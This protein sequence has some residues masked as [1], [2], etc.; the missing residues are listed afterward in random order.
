MK[1]LLDAYYDNNFG[2]DLFI[3][4]V[5]KRYPHHMFYATTGSLR[6]MFAANPPKYPQKAYE[7]INSIPNVSILPDCQAFVDSGFFDGYIMIGGDVFPDQCNYDLRMRF[8]ESIKKT[9]GFAAMIGFSLYDSYSEKTKNDMA[10]VFRQVDFIAARDATSTA[11][12]R[13][14]L[15]DKEI[16]AG[17]DLAFTQSYAFDGER[18][19]QTLGFSV[20]KSLGA[21]E[22]EYQ[23]YCQAMASIADAYL[24]RDPENKV[25]FIGLSNGSSDD[26]ETIMDIVGLMHQ[27]ENVHISRYEGCVEDAAGEIAA[28]GAMV[29]TRFHSLVFALINHIPFIPVAYEVKTQYLLRQLNY[30]GRAIR[31][32]E[33]ID[34]QRML[35]NLSETQ[36]EPSFF[37]EY[38]AKKEGMFGFLDERL[39]QEGKNHAPK[40]S[41]LYCQPQRDLDRKTAELLQAKALLA[42]K[43]ATIKSARD[44]IAGLIPSRSIQM[45]HLMKRIKEQLIKGNRHEKRDFLAWLLLRRNNTDFRFQPLRA[46]YERLGEEM[47]MQA[48]EETEDVTGRS[49]NCLSDPYHQSDVFILGIIDFDFRHQ[50]P[51]HFAKKFAEAGHRVFYI[52]PNFHKASSVVLLEAGLHAVSFYHP[53]HSAIY[54]TDWGDNAE[55]M[56]RC[57]DQLIAQYAIRDAVVVVDYPNWIFAAKHLKDTYGFKTVTDYMD[58]FTGFLNTS[59]TMLKANCERLLQESDGVAASSS[60]LYD[61]AKRYNPNTVVIRNGTEASHFE[62]AAG[63][64]R[65]KKRK[66]VGYYGAVAEWFDAKLVCY[67]ADQ[68]PECDFVL[69]GQVTHKTGEFAKRANIQLLGEKPYAELPA[70]VATFDVCLIPFDTSTDLIKAT[71]PVKFYEY[72]SAGKKIVATEIPELFPFRDEYVYLANDRK[73]FLAYVRLCL[74]GKDTLQSKEACVAMGRENDWAK[75]FEAFKQLCAGA[76]PKASIVVLTYNNLALNKLCIDSIL[77][78]TAYPNYELIIVDNV[79]TDGTDEYLQQL[80]KRALPQVKIIF[81]EQ[82]IGFA[83]GNNVGIRA[84][85]GQ[86]IVLLNN[87]TI[88]TRGWLTALI[89]HLERAPELGMCGPVTN[90]I[91][92]EAKIAVHYDS[93]EEMERFAFGYTSAHMN[94]AYP[95]PRVLAMFCVAIKRAVIDACGLLD[96]RYGLGMFEDD[97]YAE[98]VRRAGYSLC[99]A[100]DSFV[101]HFHGASFDKIK[102]AKKRSLFEANKKRFEK[103]WGEQWRAHRHRDGVTPEYMGRIEVGGANDIERE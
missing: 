50:R 79:S 83:A 94:Q 87:D 103:K 57:F 13:S 47:R 54:E 19:G 81:N 73:A 11:Y 49:P 26:G 35:D 34:A 101:H 78:K 76:A 97:D 21:T 41:E 20:R 80:Q 40:M 71:N 77:T 1:I 15:P 75:R 42:Q 16:H 92:N 6:G 72:L 61:I 22:E 91:G 65:E 23:G 93:A 53:S 52:N 37:E 44:Q 70:H 51:Q 33:E 28:C 69:I 17:M 39:S 98:A 99:I 102:D 68:L 8:V 74:E 5:T 32:G 56:K 88:V 45:M 82:N 63:A 24:A 59:K 9:G 27:P 43:N 3:D 7:R 29:C 38:T 100:E 89:K 85:D 48:T 60:F 86:Y 55:E 4:I 64:E 12:L 90:S 2:D 67:L 36:Y 96:E 58:D 18:D 31:Y 84:A 30:K 95:S 46:I 66:I 25:K 62:Q 14:M 10:R